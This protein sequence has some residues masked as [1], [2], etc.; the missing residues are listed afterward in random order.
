MAE[1]L[2]NAGFRTLFY[3]G[4][5]AFLRRK[6]HLHQ[7][8]DTYFNDERDARK[9]TRRALAGIGGAAGQRFFAYIHY[10]DV[11]LP[12][13]ENEFNYLFTPR[14]EDSRFRVGRIHH[15]RVKKLMLSGKL[16][17]EDKQYIEALYDGQIR[18]VDQ[19]IEAIVA[20]LEDQ[21][22]YEETLLVITSDHGEEFWDH[23]NFEHGHSMYEEL[24]RVPLLM[25]GNGLAHAVVKRTVRLTDLLPTVLEATGI[26]PV[27]FHPEGVT[28]PAADGAEGLDE[29]P[30]VF[31]MNTIY[32]PEK[33]GVIR[34]R[35][36]LI[37]NTHDRSGGKGKFRG[38]RS[39]DEFELYDIAAD[40][41][42]RVNLADEESA[43]DELFRL[44]QMLGALIKLRSPFEKLQVKIDEETEEQL[45]ALGY[46]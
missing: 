36:K 10:M 35:W 5:N 1:M 39:R 12:Y 28:L 3:S 20:W 37:F 25:V 7:G 11:H 17:D 19:C 44:K 45:R 18:Y 8:F 13:G 4:K 22:L 43:A 42:E 6:Y 2:K 31:V 29:E 40:P 27:D 16:T 30:Q 21:G 34:G 15:R 33:Y 14:Q 46:L 26:E 38:Y 9:L 23:K 32:G 41:L 24:V